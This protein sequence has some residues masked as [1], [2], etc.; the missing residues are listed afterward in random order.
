MRRLLALLFLFTTLPVIAQKSDDAIL[1]ELFAVKTI[2]QTAISP[3]GKSVAWSTDAGISVDGKRLS[4]APEKKELDEVEFAWSPDSK[5]VAF[6]SDAAK[7]GQRQLYIVT[8]GKIAKKL[9][10]VRGY[11]SNP[12]WSRDGKSVGFLFTENA[13]RAAGPLVAMSRAVGEIAEHLE[14]Q[15]VAIVDVATGKLRV[16]T[17]EDTYVYEYDWSPD[18]KELAVVAVQGSG[19]DNWWIAQLQTVDVAAATGVAPVKMSSIYKPELQIAS[20]RWSPD[21]K[22][23]AFVEG[24][25]SDQ[26]VTGGDLFVIDKTGGQARNLTPSAPF[27]VASLR[28]S[29]ADDITFGANMAGDSAIAIV[30]ATGGDPEIVFRGA[31][32]ITAGDVIGASFSKDGTQSAVIRSS[33]GQPPEVWAGK[34]GTWK[35]LSQLNA[36]VTAHIGEVKKIEWSSD[37]YHPYGWLLQPQGVGQAPSPVKH[38]LIVWIHGGPASA[39]LNRWPREE[40]LMLA[41]HGYFV[42]FPNPRGS[43]GAGEAFT[44]ANVKDFGYGDL[45]DILSGVD[46]VV[47]S[48]PIDNERVGIWGWSYGGYMTMWAVTQTARFKAAVA[49]AGISNWQSYYGENDIDRWMIPYFG[50]S[51]YDDPQVYAKS[52]PMTF[53][54]QVKTP[55]LILAGERD[56]EVPAP[57]SFEFFHA[58]KTLGVP[59]RLVI[60]EGEGHRVAKPEHRRDIV[61]RLIGWFDEKM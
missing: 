53:I 4:A 6:L 3:D 19:D 36:N 59:S 40:A 17:P 28:W 13:A 43:Y 33:F 55:T 18:S 24:L 31:E 42:F 15:R 7:K 39:V 58:L 41:R 35:Q 1:N 52:S 51:V 5:Q 38:P 46:E 60:Y 34:T 8:P 22:R 32:F 48:A 12:E 11:L 27:S 14:E 30:P 57:Q 50:A 21:G 16:V 37:Q 9:T 56:G 61:R 45:R 54:K 23:I 25:M 10:D 29:G 20:P 44:R 2:E 26:G 47:K 49:G